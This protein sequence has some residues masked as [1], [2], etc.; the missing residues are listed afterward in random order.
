MNEKGSLIVNIGRYYNIKSITIQHNDVASYSFEP[1]VEI[2]NPTNGT[3][4]EGDDAGFQLNNASAIYL[5]NSNGISFNKRLAVPAGAVSSWTMDGGALKNNTQNKLCLSISNL[6]EGDRVRI[7]YENGTGLS[8]A[9]WIRA[10]YFGST[11]GQTDTDMNSEAF[12]DVNNNGE[13]DEGI[14]TAIAKNDEVQRIFYTMTHDGHLDMVVTPGVRITKIEIY[15]DHRAQIE[16]VNNGI[17]NGE[18]KGYTMYFSGTGQIKEKTYYIP[19]GLNVQFGNDNEN[20]HA[21]VTA[22]DNGPVSYI[23]D[24]QGF[25]PARNGGNNIHENVPTTG[26]YYRFIPEV[27]GIIHFTFKGYSVRYEYDDNYPGGWV[28]WDANGG[29]LTDVLQYEHVGTEAYCPY[30]FYVANGNNVSSTNLWSAGSHNSSSQNGVKHEALKRVNNNI[31]LTAGNVYYL[32]GDWNGDWANGGYCGVARLLDVTFIPD[33]YVEP[34]ALVIDNNTSAQTNLALVD[35]FKNPVVKKCL[36]NITSAEPYISGNQLCIRNIQFKS[37]AD[38]AGVVLIQFKDDNG[39]VLEEPVFTLTVAYNPGW[40]TDTYGNS[41]GHTWDFSS[42]PLAIGRYADTNSQLYQETNESIPDWKFTHRSKD[43]Q[44]NNLDPMFLN[45]YD[46]AGDNADMIAETEGLWFDTGSG[47]SCLYNE[48]EGSIDRS[49]TT[50]ADPD[51]YVGILPGGS[52]T[53]PKLKQYDRVTIFMG[54]GQGSAT[55]GIFLNITNALD[56]LGTPINSEY[57]IGGSQFNTIDNHGDPWYRGC[58]HFIAAADGDMVFDM[59]GGSMCKIYEISIYRGDHRDTNNLTRGQDGSLMYVNDEGAA[60]G[61]GGIFNLHY[62]GKGEATSQPE[63]LVASG[64]LSNDKSFTSSKLYTSGHDVHFTS[65]VGDFGTFRMRAKDMD[66]TGNY[67]CDFGDMNITVGLRQ[68]LSYPYTWDFTDIAAAYGSASDLA[69]ENT[70]YPET[71]NPCENKGWEISMWDADG[72]MVVRNIDP[73]IVIGHESYAN[74]YEIFS[75]YKDGKVANQLYANGKIIPETQ[76][77]WF[78]FDNNDGSYNGCMQITEEGLR[79]SNVKDAEGVRRGWWNNKIVVPSVPAGA[80]VYVRAARDNNVKETDVD[81]QGVSFFYVSYQFAS[82]SAKAVIGSDDNSKLYQ[83][84][85]NSGDYIMAIYNSGEEQNLTFT[86]NGWILKKMSISSDKKTLDK[87]G[88]ATES[89]KHVID[90]ALTAYLTGYD[91]RTYFLTAANYSTKQARVEAVNLNEGGE[92][93]RAIANDGETGACIIGNADGG[94]VSILDGG[95]HLFVP[96]MHDYIGDLDANTTEGC[97]KTV[98]S[99][100][101]SILKAKVDPGYIAP[102][103]VNGTITNY[104]LTA[105]HKIGEEGDNIDDNVSAFYRVNPKA[106]GGQGAY[107]YG[108]NA[109]LQL[110]TESLSSSANAFEIVFDFDNDDTDGINE[111]NDRKAATVDG[112]YTIDG[113]KLNGMPNTSGLYIVNGKKV[114][115]K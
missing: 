45:Q 19:G 113:Q 81:D 55:N 91:L 10:I 58:Y 36:G 114:V 34:L 3:L 102:T 24:H 59:V 48:H 104:I 92:I 17:V 64:N 29:Q 103:A 60:N 2:Y 46:M 22:T 23:N 7:T 109:Y 71:T 94:P 11:E 41:E 93:V 30:A 89:R 38:P 26:T 33:N 18:N 79:L 21:F 25:K 14:E 84:N 47:L 96:D 107:S 51:R 27:D 57:K 100:N 63:V 115:I 78:Y 62:R 70:N 9:N 40:N 5:V 12:G 82:M 49:N 66:Y 15:S 35:G 85:D 31:H 56:A 61:N 80:A 54:S 42:D 53:I 83:A 50:Q 20:E 88:W 75:N 8:D 105:Y 108:N 77:L 65:T 69:A 99:A 98:T 4:S 97:I 28:Y 74:R 72:K 39:N 95:F 67:V 73:S 68:K 111:V 16:C 44:G 112:I 32:Y 6:I 37:N 1:S 43:S 101:Q 106:N 86:L 87:N 52:F 90:P 110:E 76:G 13:M